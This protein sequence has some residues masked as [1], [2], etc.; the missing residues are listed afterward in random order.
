MI[1]SSRDLR[2]TKT[3]LYIGRFQ[4]FHLGHLEAVKYVL[5]KCGQV[6]I[7]IG[8]AQYSHTLENPF[9]SGERLAMSR[10]ALNEA[11][12]QPDKYL[13][14]PIPDINVHNLWV[15][16]VV[17]YAPAFQVVFSN[18]P[19]TVVLFQ[20]AGFLVEPIPFFNRDKYSATQIREHMLKGQDWASLVP[21]SVAKFIKEIKGE[22]RLRNLNSSDK[23]P[24]A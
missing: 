7:A 13:L 18:E 17:S 22:E 2:A 11:G 23:L 6:V 20:E 1:P 24:R 5:G 8:S 19:L 4:P 14:I 9:T 12:I 21:K 3:A 15:T 16:H 10:L